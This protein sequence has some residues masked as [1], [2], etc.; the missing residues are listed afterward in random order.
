[1][2]SDNN[3]KLNPYLLGI[4]ALLF[5][6]GMYWWMMPDKNWVGVK[7]TSNHT[8]SVKLPDGSMA[9]LT[10]PSELG[11]PKTFDKDIR[12]VKMEGE[13]YFEI[14][15][16][17]NPFL[18]QSE[19]GGF[20][21]TGAQVSINTKEKE[22]ISVHCFTDSVRMIARGKVKIFDIMLGPLEMSSYY[23]SDKEINKQ[24]FEPNDVF[25][26]NL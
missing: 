9:F 25:K 13:I 24:T 15:K 5:V 7:V 26:K 4:A 21:T 14:V 23:R 22:N 1:M 2:T 17:E 19:K 16:S 20:K 10:G 11:Y 12:R 6:A 18:V 3:K 8:D